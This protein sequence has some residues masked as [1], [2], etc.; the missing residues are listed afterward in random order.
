MAD[1]VEKGTERMERPREWA[2]GI[3]TGVSS[4]LQLTTELPLHRVGL[5]DAKKETTTKERTGKLKL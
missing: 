4:N 5:L 2:P 1:I 3:Y